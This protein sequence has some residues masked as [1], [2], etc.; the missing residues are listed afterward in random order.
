MKPLRSALLLLLIAALLSAGTLRAESK[1]T[2]AEA[3]E[4]LLAGNARFVA[5]QANHPHQTADH[6]TELAAG[7]HPFAIVLTCAD[8][9][10][11]PELYFDQGLG[12]LFV[13]AMPAT[14]SMTTPSAASN[15]PS[16]TSTPPS[17]SSS[18]TPN[19]AQ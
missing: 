8:S 2:P 1:T 12:D 3:L 14:S 10:V 7:Q 16:S 19:A 18:A 6:R 17:S 13:P 4:R 5:G 15:T 9:R 11:A